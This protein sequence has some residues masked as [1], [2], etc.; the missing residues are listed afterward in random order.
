[1]LVGPFVNGAAVAI[2]GVS[3]AF[4]G[5]R[6]PERLRAQMPQTFGLASMALGVSMII[7]LHQLPAVIL[8]L[9]IGAIIGELCNLEKLF[10]AAGSS[11]KGI[12]E[13]IF[14]PT[15]GLTQEQ[16]LEKFV[17]ILVLFCASGTGIFGAMNE[18]MTGD[19]Q[20]LFVKS[21]LDLFTAAIFATALGYSVASIF[22]PQVA[23][24]LAL[25]LA[26]TTIMPLTTP[27]MIGDFSAVGGCIML[28][29]GFRICGVKPFPVANMVPGLLLAMPFS[30]MWTIL[31]AH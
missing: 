25:A 14:P 10:G 6:L 1:M 17:A 31:I 30:H 12:V 27:T 5:T 19:P 9:I 7:K 22:I 23:I 3:G 21:I 15:Q 16:Y 18:G 20:I 8:S 2:G 11:V 26:A 29:T 28:A 13:R 24:Q 4:M